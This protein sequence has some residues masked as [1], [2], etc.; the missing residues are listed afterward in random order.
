ML[1]TDKTKLSRKTIPSTTEILRLMTFAYVRQKAK[2]ETGSSRK[3]S[4]KIKRSPVFTFRRH[5]LI[6]HLLL[7]KSLAVEYLKKKIIFKRFR[8]K[9][10][11]KF[12][13][14]YSLSS[15]IHKTNQDKFTGAIFIRRL[16][17][18]TWNVFVFWSIKTILRP[19]KKGG[20]LWFYRNFFQSDHTA[21]TLQQ[22]DK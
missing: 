11:S 12:C 20:D 5:P 3:I 21:K 2:V 14:M 1:K 13:R 4:G 16:T 17:V 6:C 9:K 7:W 18:T 15:L 22:L 10:Y 8:L 19:K